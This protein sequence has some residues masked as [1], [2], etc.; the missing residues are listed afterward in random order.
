MQEKD[1]LYE[2]GRFW[3]CRAPKGWKGFEVYRISDS[4]THSVRCATIGFEGEKGLQRA[5]AE[6]ERRALAK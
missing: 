4:G 5:I 3:V 2:H 1:I 6:C